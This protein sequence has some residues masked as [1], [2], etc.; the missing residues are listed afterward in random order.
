MKIDSATGASRER[1]R[2]RAKE[3]PKDD[4]WLTDYLKMTTNEDIQSQ[5][6]GG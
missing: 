5:S 2:E 3:K 4:L 1:E 6:I